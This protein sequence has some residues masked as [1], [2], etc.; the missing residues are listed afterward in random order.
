MQNVRVPGTTEQSVT[1]RLAP[2]RWKFASLTHGSPQAFN[3]RNVAYGF[4][5]ADRVPTTEPLAIRN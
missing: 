4:Y 5:V 2:S 1:P 3:A